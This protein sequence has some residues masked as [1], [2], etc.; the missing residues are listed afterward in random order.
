MRLLW[1]SNVIMDD[2]DK[3]ATGTWLYAL[4]N[5]FA[6][7]GDVE[8]GNITQGN[9]AELTRQDFGPI[10]QWIV[11]SK[12]KSGKNGLPREHFIADIVEAVEDF[13][14]D[15][16]HI[17]GTEGFWGL[18]TARNIVKTPALLEMQGLK[19]AIARYFSGDLTT[20]ESLK[21]IGIKEIL[22]GSTIFQSRRN[23]RKWGRF[24]REII[25]KHKYVSTQ[26]KWMEA[27]V[28]DIKGSCRLF[29]ND[30]VLREPFYKADPWKYSGVPTVF[31]ASAYPAPFKGLHI[32]VRALATLKSLF[33]N[34]K[35]R[36]A[37]LHR[38]TGIRRDGYVAWVNREIHRLGLDSHITWLES[39]SAPR[40]VEE[41]HK[42]SALIVPSFIESNSIILAE[43]MLLGIPT[44]VS[45]AGGMSSR[46]QD[47][48]TALFFSPGDE[49]MCAY[50]LAR[51]LSDR[52]LAE[53]L[54]HRARE[55]A[56]VRSDPKR[57][58]QHHLETY[59]QVL[60]EENRNESL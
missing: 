38:R 49:K 42:C 9:V 46:A 10:R 28:I 30:R 1:F 50:Q 12:A 11:P 44:A 3:G 18:L 39:L 43:A 36:V 52:E 14:P 53:R 45:Y 7:S 34:I 23:F 59:R 35:L 60:V 57:I 6:D 54:S 16:V 13:Q 21:C 51:L 40:I 8:L 37:G 19:R 32:A 22:R 27:Q 29:R 56:F 24:D 2:V 31:F 5:K 25:S 17:W 26:S 15:L 20:L 58:V 47:E 48:E 41:L 55:I 33:P 4:A